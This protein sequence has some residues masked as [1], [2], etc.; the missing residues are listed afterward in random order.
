[1]AQT[2]EPMPKL[3]DSENTPQRL[4][5]ADLRFDSGEAL[6]HHIDRSTDGNQVI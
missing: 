4:T 3:A 5:V 1:M 6:R 2:T